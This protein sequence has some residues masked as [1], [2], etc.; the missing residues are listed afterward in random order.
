MTPEGGPAPSAPFPVAGVT[1]PPQVGPASPWSP[2]PVPC[3]AE[4]AWL[5][6]PWPLPGDDPPS[7]DDEPPWLAAAVAADPWY[8]GVPEPDDEWESGP[9]WQPEPAI[10]V[11]AEL[12]WGRRDPGEADREGPPWAPT[13]RRPRRRAGRPQVL[14]WACPKGGSGKTSLSLRFAAFLAAAGED[15]DRRVVWVDGNLQQAD[16]ARYLGADEH[17]SRTILDLADLADRAEV[18]ERQVLSTL[19]PP[20]RTGWPI[21]ALF[22]PAVKADADPGVVTPELYRQV[23]DRLRDHFDHIVVDTPVAEH[24]NP[25][26]AQFVVPEADQL[27][28]VVPPLLPVVR[29]VREWL[30]LQSA[31]VAGG[32]AGLPSSSVRVVLNMASEQSGCPVEAV[33]DAWLARWVWAGEIPYDPR[34]TESINNGSLAGDRRHLA[35]G[36][37]DLVRATTGEVVD[38]GRL[39]RGRVRRRW[40]PWRRA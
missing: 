1:T 10:G 35:T 27:V 29:A 24:H 33:R 32:G 15:T 18:D 14:M 8:P 7:R 22:G 6:D 38:G 4:E 11:G 34:W 26:F 17:A 13:G 30:E 21:W 9:P 20:E 40:W 28:V 31:P 5:D 25:F 19:T 37:A 36:F 16:G 12:G 39:R 23:V 2:P 3:R